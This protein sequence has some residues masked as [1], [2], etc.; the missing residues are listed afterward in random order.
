M[1]R[2]EFE[3]NWHQLK[4]KIREKWAKFTHDELNQMS[5][6][7]EQFIGSLQKKYG[8]SRERAEQEIHNW[9]LEHG[10]MGHQGDRAHNPNEKQTFWQQNK[11]ERKDFKKDN[12][13]KDKKRKAG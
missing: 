7:Y 3:G 11:N 10:G 12:D 8:H 1:N 13:W 6:K 2:D 4:G 9:K 5:G